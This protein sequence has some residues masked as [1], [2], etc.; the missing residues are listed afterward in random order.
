MA[1]GG[2]ST[3]RATGE[4]DC[5]NSHAGSEIRIMLEERGK[6]IVGILAYQNAAIAILKTVVNFMITIV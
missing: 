2:G 1:G 3:V 5:S 6:R 4:G